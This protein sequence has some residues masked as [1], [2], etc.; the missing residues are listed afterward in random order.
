MAKKR[1]KKKKEPEEETYEIKVEDW[2][3]AYRFGLNTLPKDLIQGV[4]WE[5]ARL[6]HK[7]DIHI[8]DIPPEYKDL[9]SD[10]EF[11]PDD[12]Q[13]L[14]EFGSACGRESPGAHREDQPRG[15]VRRDGGQ[16]RVPS[17]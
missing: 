14:F 11:N 16:A 13:R 10:M 2:E 15:G 4:Y 1:K 7:M 6:I 9:Q 17:Y 5:R 8:S 12:M 3:A